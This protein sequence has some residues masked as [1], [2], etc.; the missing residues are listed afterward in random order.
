[1]NAI[2]E[3]QGAAKKPG[4]YGVISWSKDLEKGMTPDEI[5]EK[6]LSIYPD[7]EKEDAQFWVRNR[8]ARMPVGASHDFSKPVKLKANEWLAYHYRIGDGKA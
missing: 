7:Q 4:K 8:L 1:M 5:V 6:I 3:A 2:K